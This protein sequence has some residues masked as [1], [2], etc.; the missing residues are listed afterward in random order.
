VPGSKDLPVQWDNSINADKEKFVAGL[1]EKLKPEFGWRI[2]QFRMGGHGDIRDF[3]TKQNEEFYKV[4]TKDVTD[5]A[6]QQ[7]DKDP[8]IPNLQVQQQKTEE[9]IDK[10]GLSNL[11]KAKAKQEAR[12]KLQGTSL[13]HQ[14]LAGNEATSFPSYIE[15]HEGFRSRAYP[16]HNTTT[17]AF[18]GYELGLGLTP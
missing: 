5:K 4:G 8:S 9:V 1:P 16:D 10:S 18:A 12:Q 13:Y 2:D 3:Q 6:V 11:D 15:G 14:K 7:V 17:H